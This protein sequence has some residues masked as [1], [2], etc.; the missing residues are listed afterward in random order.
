[1]KFVHDVNEVAPGTDVQGRSDQRRV[2]S[3]FPEE[4]M[5]RRPRC[6]DGV[7]TLARRSSRFCDGGVLVVMFFRGGHVG[8]DDDAIQCGCVDGDL[9]LLLMDV[10]KGLIGRSDVDEAVTD[11]IKPRPDGISELV[12]RGLV[13]KEELDDEVLGEA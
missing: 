11:L 7:Q 1:M 4:P 8:N 5:Y 12:P 6:R 9:L 13:E 3:R 10:Q 2:E